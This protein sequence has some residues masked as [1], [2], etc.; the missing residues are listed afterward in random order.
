MTNQ[1]TKSL[2]IGMLVVV[3]IS[4]KELHTYTYLIGFALI[5]PGSK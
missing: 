1:I 2:R 3:V 5:H 4:Q